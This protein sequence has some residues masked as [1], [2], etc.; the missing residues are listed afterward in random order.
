M[1]S[2]ELLVISV[3]CMQ[4]MKMMIVVNCHQLNPM[5]EDIFQFILLP[6]QVTSCQVLILYI[7]ILYKSINEPE[8]N[9]KVKVKCKIKG[10]P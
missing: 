6:T 2:N 1:H 10:N 4:D 9:C 5:K 8:W 3:I 7:L